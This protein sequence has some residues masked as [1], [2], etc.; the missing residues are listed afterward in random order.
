MARWARC[1]PFDLL[2]FLSLPHTVTPATA[3]NERERERGGGEASSSGGRERRRW[4]PFVGFACRLGSTRLRRLVLVG[5]LR[6]A[7]ADA[8]GRRKPA[9][10]RASNADK[11]AR[12]RSGRQGYSGLSPSTPAQL[13]GLLRHRRG[14]R[15]RRDPQRKVAS[16][17]DNSRVMVRVLKRWGN[18]GDFST[19]EFRV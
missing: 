17:T 19:L 2:S 10:R 5:V 1:G 11:R 13:R 3:T 6:E 7:D 16:A 4:A 18:F 8:H 14:Q 9:R 12:R 15:R